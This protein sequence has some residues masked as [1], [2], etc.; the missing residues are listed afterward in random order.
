MSKKNP[1]GPIGG[2]PPEN[3][4]RYFVPSIGEP[5]AHELLRMAGLRKGERVLDVGCGTGIV[6]RLAAEQVGATGIVV[7]IDIDAGMLAVARSVTPA[8]LEIAWR[9]GSAESLPLEDESFD[10]A[11]C[12]MS[13]QFVDDP[14][15][16]L[17]EMH[18]V[19]RPGGRILLDVPGRATPQF[20]ALGASM[21]KH[22]AK[23]A[24]G[25]VDRVFSLHSPEA[26]EALIAKAGFRGVEVRTATR[27]LTLPAPREFLRQ[28]VS[29]TP[30]AGALSGADADARDAFEADVLD[31][32]EP[33]AEA[34][35]MAMDQPMVF[36]RALK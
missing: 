25:F 29:S 36:A 14:R 15:K 26:V 20:E 18:R 21:G 3:Y 2:R 34:D 24:K 16:A 11:L 5:M 10:V 4:E 23:E 27:S 6:T 19:L 1:A 7:G 22:I 13:L 17:A 28:Y 31:A 8:G 12:Q 33:F 32:W 35:G 9:E 30:L